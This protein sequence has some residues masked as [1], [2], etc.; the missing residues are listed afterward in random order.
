MGWCVI[1]CIRQLKRAAG[2]DDKEGWERVDLTRFRCLVPLGTGCRGDQALCMPALFRS[3]SGV[4]CAR[5]HPWFIRVCTPNTGGKGQK[6]GEYGLLHHRAGP[7]WHAIRHHHHVVIFLLGGMYP[8]VCL[9]FSI[10]SLGHHVTV[11]NPGLHRVFT[12]DTGGKGQK[13]GEYGRLHSSCDDFWAWS[14][15]WCG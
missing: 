15:F 9:P 13:V 7:K 1:R 4:L 12:L 10:P 11:S 8:A 14:C 2:V 3:I 6:V 5:F